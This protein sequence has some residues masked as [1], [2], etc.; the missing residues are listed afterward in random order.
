MALDKVFKSD[1]LFDYLPSYWKNSFGDRPVLETVYEALVRSMDVDWVRLFAVNDAKDLG[2]TPITTP[3]PLVHQVLGAWDSLK[4]P[5]AHYHAWFNWPT[6]SGDPSTYMI[7]VEGHILERP[8]LF[9]DGRA[10]PGFVYRL[11]AK[12]WVESGVVKYGSTITFNRSELDAFLDGSYLSVPGQ[13]GANTGQEWVPSDLIQRVGILAYRDNRPFVGSGDGVSLSYE[14]TIGAETALIEPF[15]AKAV[16][17]SLD[18]T[19][20]VTVA[21]VNGGFTITPRANGGFGAGMLLQVTFDDDTQAVQCMESS[22]STLTF[23][24]SAGDVVSA[25]LFVEIP[26]GYKHYEVT[27]SGVTMLG[28]GVFPGGTTLRVKDAAGIQ[29]KVL[30][31]PRSRVMFER[32]INTDS[33]QVLY[34]GTSLTETVVDESRI[35]F[36]RPLNT[37][38]IW[39]IDA[40]IVVDHDHAL[41]RTVTDGTALI[42]LPATRP[43]SLSGGAFQA[44]HPVLVFIDG[45]LQDPTTYSPS[46]SRII[47]LDAA[48]TADIPVDVWYVDDEDPVEH[49][50]NAL[51][52]VTPLTVPEQY[53]VHYAAA[54]T[55]NAARWPVTLFRDGFLD[56]NPDQIVTVGGQ[57]IQLADAL[58]PGISVQI[59]A[60][61]SEFRY[62]HVIPARTDVDYGYQ[63]RIHS[64]GTVQD[65]VSAPGTVL[66]SGTG[67]S[68]APATEPGQDALLTASVAWDEAWLTDVEVDE[69]AL[70]T[71]WGAPIGV[72]R[73]NSSDR[74]RNLLAAIYGAYRGPSFV[75]SLANFS[76]ILLGSAYLPTAGYSRG[77]VRNAAGSVVRIQPTDPK[78]DAIEI[79]LLQDQ[80]HRILDGNIEMARLRAVNQLVTVQDRDLSSVPWLA[81]MAQ[82]LSEDYGYANRLDVRDAHSFSSVPAVFDEPTQVITDYSVNFY[83]QEVWPGDLVK[84]VLVAGT[85]PTTGVTTYTAD[86]LGT[87]PVTRL[88]YDSASIPPRLN[89]HVTPPAPLVWNSGYYLSLSGAGSPWDTAV[90]EALTV[91]TQ[92]PG[93]G[94]GGSTLIKADWLPTH[95]APSVNVLTPSSPLPVLQGVVKE[96]STT[97]PSIASTIQFSSVSAVL[98]AHNIRVP[99]VVSSEHL[100]YGD[101]HYGEHGYG[102]GLLQSTPSAYTVWTRRTRRLDTYLSLDHALDQAYA[103]VPGESVQLL[104]QELAQVLRHNVFTME[105]AWGQM[106]DAEALGDLAILIQGIKPAETRALVYT[107]AFPDGVLSG[108]LTGSMIDASPVIETLA[109]TLFMGESWLTTTKAAS[110]GPELNYLYKPWEHRFGPR[111]ESELKAPPTTPVEGG[112]YLAAP[113][114]NIEHTGAWAK[115]YGADYGLEGTVL[116]YYASPARWVV[117]SGFPPSAGFATDLSNGARRLV[118]GPIGS[119]TAQHSALTLSVGSGE[120]VTVHARV[121][122]PSAS[123]SA[124]GTVYISSM[125]PDVFQLGLIVTSPGLLQPWFRAHAVDTLALVESPSASY[126]DR[127]VSL[128]GVYREGVGGYWYSD[129]YVDDGVLAATSSPSGSASPTVV[130]ATGATRL[131]L[132]GRTASPNTSESFK[133]YL[134]EFRLYAGTELSNLEIAALWNGGAPVMPEL[135]MASDGS[136]VAPA[137]ISAWYISEHHDLGQVVD[138]SGQGFIATKVSA[139]ADD[140]LKDWRVPGLGRSLLPKLGDTYEVKVGGLYVDKGQVVSSLLAIPPTLSSYSPEMEDVFAEALGTSTLLPT[141]FGYNDVL[142][143]NPAPWLHFKDTAGWVLSSSNP[144]APGSALALDQDPVFLGFSS[145]LALDAGGIS[146]SP[147]SADIVLVGDRLV[148]TAGANNA[149]ALT[150]LSLDGNE[151]LNASRKG[152]ATQWS[153][154]YTGRGFARLV[155]EAGTLNYSPD[156]VSNSVLLSASAGDTALVTSAYLGHAAGSLVYDGA[157]YVAGGTVLHKYVELGFGANSNVVKV[158]AHFERDSS[159][160]DGAWRS[161]F[162]TSTVA[163]L[164]QIW[165]YQPGVNEAPV[166]ITA[167]G[168][169][170]Y[171]TTWVGGA[172][173]SNQAQ[174]L[175]IGVF[176]RK[177]ATA[178]GWFQTQLLAAPDSVASSPLGIYSSLLNDQEF[179]GAN[180][181]VSAGSF[182]TERY[183]V[184]G[185]LIEVVGG[186][187]QLAYE[188]EGVQPL[189]TGPTPATYLDIVQGPDPMTLGASF[190]LVVQ[191]K[192][193]GGLIDTGFNLTGLLSLVSGP[194]TLSGD[195]NPVFI[196]GEAVVSPLTLSLSGG[197]QVM[198]TAAGLA[199][200]L[201]TVQV[202]NP[203][204]YAVS[205]TYFISSPAQ[206]ALTL[207]GTDFMSVS[208]VVY[209]NWTGSPDPYPSTLT[210]VSPG[211]VRF[212]P[213]ATILSASPQTLTISVHNPGPGGGATGEIPLTIESPATPSPT[214][215]IPVADHML[216]STPP[217]LPAFPRVGQATL[218]GAV[219]VDSTL[220]YALDVTASGSVT[221]SPVSMPAGAVIG[222]VLSRELGAVAAGYSVFTDITFNRAGT[223]VLDVVHESPAVVATTSPSLT[224]FVLNN[225]PTVTSLMPDNTD[226]GTQSLTLQVFGT[227]FVE[228]DTEVLLSGFPRPTT[229]VSPGEVTALLGASD[230]LV[231]Q[232][233]GISVLTNQGGGASSALTFTVNGGVG[234]GLAEED[235]SP[236]IRVLGPD[237]YQRVLPVEGSVLTAAMGQALHRAIELTGKATNGAPIHVYDG[238]VGAIEVI[239]ISAGAYSALGVRPGAQ[240]VAALNVDMAWPPDALHPLVIRAAKWTTSTVPVGAQVGAPEPVV[241]MPPPND[242]NNSGDTLGHIRN[243]LS[244]Y[245]HLYDINILTA[246]RTGMITMDNKGSGTGISNP[247]YSWL[248]WHFTRCPLLGR[249]DHRTYRL[250]HN[251]WIV[252]AQEPVAALAQFDND[253]SVLPAKTWAL[254]DLHRARFG[255][256]LTS[257]NGFASSWASLTSIPAGQ[258]TAIHSAVFVDPSQNVHRVG[259]ASTSGDKLV[260]IGLGLFDPLEPG[261]AALGTDD[262]IKAAPFNPITSPLQYATPPSLSYTMDV[263]WLTNGSFDG[264]PGAGGTVQVW[265]RVDDTTLSAGAVLTSAGTFSVPLTHGVSSAFISLTGAGSFAFRATIKDELGNAVKDPANPDADLTRNALIQVTQHGM[266][267]SPASIAVVYDIP[268]LEVIALSNVTWALDTNWTTEPFSVIL[269]AR[270]DQGQLSMEVD[271]AVRVSIKSVKTVEGVDITPTP[272]ILSTEQD[273]LMRGGVCHVMDLHPQFTSTGPGDLQAILSASAYSYA[274][275]T[276][277]MTPVGTGHVSLDS[278]EFTYELGVWPPGGQRGTDPSALPATLQTYP[279]AARL[280]DKAWLGPVV[281]DNWLAL[282]PNSAISAIETN[283]PALAKIKTATGLPFWS[284]WPGD[285]AH[286]NFRLGYQAIYPDP[287]ICPNLTYVGYPATVASTKWAALPFYCDDWV[288]EGGLVINIEQEH[289]FYFHNTAGDTAVRDSTIMNV[290]RTAIQKADRRLENPY[291]DVNDPNDTGGPGRGVFRVSNNTIMET[292]LNDGGGSITLAGHGPDGELIVEGNAV[293]NGY[294][295]SLAAIRNISD[296]MFGASMTVWGEALASTGSTTFTLWSLGFKTNGYQQWNPFLLRS[297]G[298]PVFTYAEI[299]ANLAHKLDYFGALGVVGGDGTPVPTP[300]WYTDLLYGYPMMTYAGQVLGLTADD[301]FA[302][303]SPQVYLGLTPDPI[304]GMGSPTYGSMHQN[305]RVTVRNN[306]FETNTP[307]QGRS[308]SSALPSLNP[309]VSVYASGTTYSNTPTVILGDM[310]E[311]IFDNNTIHQSGSNAL[312]LDETVSV[313]TSPLEKT[314][315]PPSGISGGDKRLIMKNAPIWQLSGGGNIIPGQILRFGVSAP[316]ALIQQLTSP[317]T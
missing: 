49:L 256:R 237:T 152:R 95:A 270:T 198:V 89:L 292:G 8:Q 13:T 129:I 111:L 68:F 148:V 272:Y 262:F 128:T 149:G 296:G 280:T 308:W 223:Y 266:S 87:A 31:A 271:G 276:L 37:G 61:R 217:A 57:F 151:L 15:D 78:K 244:S 81:F 268:D 144:Q 72:L 186:F 209:S 179:L 227:N 175:A 173:L 238:S 147:L 121:W 71:V 300:T 273:H 265:D 185:T 231:P 155:N 219:A 289:G 142:Y 39:R 62:R 114:G 162:T 246:S 199:P 59:D 160:K 307:I 164:N 294:D 216:F 302:G 311:L 207:Y 232:A 96:Q 221:L 161:Q 123:Y 229:Y 16:I 220:G 257:S 63:G 317:A 202:N 182:R 205:P 225:A 169:I 159:T 105:L 154:E 253:G 242:V 7:R 283:A 156:Q 248:G 127:W 264:V 305:G 76:S 131:T 109:D 285:P 313:W 141:L 30:D 208:Y 21:V 90:S 41:H 94:A 27:S 74:Y 218:L 132:G 82:D 165:V 316:A 42:T 222:G 17:E 65:G 145:P 138:I 252:G 228:T 102:G 295:D 189:I 279:W 146:H 40:P 66:E 80:P 258:I 303:A 84:L 104:N 290:G 226:Q 67:F 210:Y 245:W 200:D 174:D 315:T 110:F 112:F 284:G 274:I 34:L 167:P 251:R 250:D 54:D 277:A 260:H 287:S 168:A 23:A 120:P 47:A 304:Y 171:P 116:R 83:D 55:F 45:V 299:Q 214:V 75:D 133:G 103:L 53:S 126:Y 98:D 134:D 201:V 293:F 187:N 181:G 234:S 11:N 44:D 93:A 18:V 203:A 158:S 193:S 130:P 56:N 135:G 143:T 153:C 184:S 235:L 236:T 157:A 213:P 163:A 113:K 170:N 137:G 35:T 99:V 166:S 281:D 33:A 124:P 29:S 60:I 312:F 275:M 4:V 288:Y 239:E 206:G 12:H 196:D 43:M 91:L 261:L 259:L 204:P 122:I 77:I 192:G 241:L 88:V 9:L 20:L 255:R 197:Y 64:I 107:E 139:V 195:L 2:A 38:V 3:H 32:P 125:S 243:P 5:H 100:G 176:H 106:V 310:R 282:A 73:Y 136:P 52:Q 177:P 51:S 301:G 298:A 254:D 247:T 26:L 86:A 79:A 50:H 278:Q 297:N 180:P 119:A 108:Q 188:L 190:G 291:S 6:P 233:Y 249:H 211:E 28:G 118:A 101:A 286:P 46:S 140:V 1:A 183:I 14:L 194:G 24:S 191:A 115:T 172:I 85:S 19:Q 306:L 117:D 240:P 267:A 269:E 150:Q 212:T 10:V 230:F 48:L 215:V 25:R 69:R 92:S 58:T 22:T 309:Y 314:S 36:V 263:T 224:L 70:H 178:T 97:T